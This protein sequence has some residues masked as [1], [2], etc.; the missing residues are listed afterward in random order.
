[1]CYKMDSLIIGLGTV[2]F[3]LFY[4]LYNSITVDA[5]LRY[6]F[7]LGFNIGMG[8]GNIPEKDDFSLFVSTLWMLIGNFVFF[9][10]CLAIVKAALG[11][12]TSSLFQRIAVS[13]RGF[14]QSISERTGLSLSGISVA[15]TILWALF[16]V[17]IGV[18]V[19]DWTFIKSLNFAVG[20]MTTTGSQ[21]CS[22]EPL[23]NILTAIFLFGGVPLLS[24]T[25]SILVV[26]NIIEHD[27]DIDKLEKKPM[28][29]QESS[30]RF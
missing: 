9:S 12:N 17:C 27:V 30:I 2:G 28:V 14:M 4:T 20:G 3:I 13:S 8:D 15:V 21:S 6:I 7:D 10:W 26:P 1:M 29:V 23:S 16:G 11:R 19:E 5:A 18:F 22:N 25:T 24:I